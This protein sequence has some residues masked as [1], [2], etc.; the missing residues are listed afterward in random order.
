VVLLKLFRRWNVE[1]W[2]Q[3]SK[4]LRLCQA[5]EDHELVAM[6]VKQLVTVVAMFPDKHE[7]GW[8]HPDRKRGHLAS[9]LAG[10]HEDQI[11]AP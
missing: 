1:L 9:R 5:G 10:E 7:P 3:S 11:E 6:D 2:N 8:F 4:A